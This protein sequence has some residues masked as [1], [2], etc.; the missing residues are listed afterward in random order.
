MGFEFFK[1]RLPLR[2]KYIWEEARSLERLDYRFKMNYEDLNDNGV[3]RSKY[4]LGTLDRTMDPYVDIEL[5]KR[6]GEVRLISS[7]VDDIKYFQKT[8]LSDYLSDPELYHSAAFA[9]I[10]GKSAVQCARQHEQ[11]EW[12][13]KIDLK[14]FFHSIDERMIY[15]TLLQ[16]RVDNYV[17]FMLARLLTR[18]VNSE[19]E[20]YKELPRKY[21][22][23]LRHS[24]IPK[25]GVLE[26]RLGFLPQG[27][28]AS[29]AVS[30]LVC[31]DLD[32]RLSDLATLYGLTYTRYADDIIFSSTDMFERKFAEKVLRSASMTIRKKGFRLHARKTRIVPPGAR[33]Q[34]LG[35]LVGAPGLRLL[36]K[37]RFQIDSDLRAIAKFG[38]RRHAKKSGLDN[39]L[40]LLNRV[41]GQ[42]V[43]AH[44]VNREWAEPR[45]ESLSRLAATQLESLFRRL[46]DK[47]AKKVERKER[48]RAKRIENPPAWKK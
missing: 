25:F 3:I 36:R 33:R 32:N 15:W 47:A 8:L 14:D 23:N 1:P 7:P 21:K 2:S 37:T 34:V 12:L 28:P 6:S 31:F 40:S 41:F 44:E 16:R 35:V 30:N 4:L 19:Q 10:P 42:L 24:L 9:Y 18:A 20:I 38:F 27:G 39:E 26:K 13:I 22:R 43:W 45:M 17:S 5:K 29:G 48:A 46:D 11:A